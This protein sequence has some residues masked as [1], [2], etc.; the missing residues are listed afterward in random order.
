MEFRIKNHVLTE[1]IDA[2]GITAVEIER[3]IIWHDRSRS[4]SWTPEMKAVA[5][6]KTRERSKKC[7]K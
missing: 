5:G 7:P 3:T 6:Q 1:V 2:D 4:E